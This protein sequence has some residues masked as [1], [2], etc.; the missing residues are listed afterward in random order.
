MLHRTCLALAVALGT[1]V[2]APAAQATSQ[3]SHMSHMSQ[4]SPMS[5]PRPQASA[6]A[7]IKNTAG[8][9]VG[10]LSI[11]EQPDG[12]SKL[13][14][15]VGGLSAGYHGFHVHMKGVCDPKSIDPVTGSPF[16]SAG[17]HFTIPPVKHSNHSGDLPNL[18]VAADGTGAATVV[19]D[20]FKVGQLFDGDGSAIVI[21]AL[22]D[23]H[24][25]I[26]DRYSH[27]ADPTPGTGPDAET[28][29]AGDSG[30]RIACGVITGNR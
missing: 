10:S 29:K 28:L 26:P 25:N 7:V 11:V 3:M 30:G 15:T 18:L 23:N 16:A 9:N 6:K 2:P 21:H 22:P 4:I 5:S 14:I 19:T 20:R 1:T 12:K 13:T 8:K 17:P 27:P 24:S